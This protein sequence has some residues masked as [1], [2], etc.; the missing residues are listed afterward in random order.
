M[1]SLMGWRT[2]TFAGDFYHVF[3]QPLHVGQYVIVVAKTR[4]ER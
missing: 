4:L 1:K 2:L 3:Q